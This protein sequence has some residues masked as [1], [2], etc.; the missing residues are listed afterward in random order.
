MARFSCH[1]FFFDLVFCNNESLAKFACISPSE[2]FAILK[3]S[4]TD[5]QRKQ[6]RSCLQIDS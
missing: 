5:E 1:D 2:N 4:K 6:N 3:K